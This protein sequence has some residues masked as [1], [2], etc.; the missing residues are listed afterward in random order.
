MKLIY[1]I[2]ELELVPKNTPTLNLTTQ[3]DHDDSLTVLKALLG[4]DSVDIVSSA[5]G[6]KTMVVTHQNENMAIDAIPNLLSMIRYHEK[7]IYNWIVS[8]TVDSSV[9]INT[10]NKTFQQVQNIISESRPSLAASLS[11][12]SIRETST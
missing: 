7:D 2:G 5:A 4:K 1:K 3:R 11:H 6:A 12:C 9:T 8:D 10:L